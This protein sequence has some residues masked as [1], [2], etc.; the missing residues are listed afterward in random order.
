MRTRCG[1]LVY[2]HH[3]LPDAVVWAL[4]LLLQGPRQAVR[5][6]CACVV[7]RVGGQPVPMSPR[8]HLHPARDLQRVHNDQRG[9]AFALPDDIPFIPRRHPRHWSDAVSAPATAARATGVRRWTCTL[10]RTFAASSSS[11]DVL[12]P[13]HTITA[14]L[15][16]TRKQSMADSSC[17]A[18]SPTS[19]SPSC[20][21]VLDT[22]NRRCGPGKSAGHGTSSPRPTRFASSPTVTAT[23]TRSTM[24]GSTARRLAGAE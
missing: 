17:M 13:P 14:R 6:V 11:T 12:Q 10:A 21:S 24:T 3:D 22:R 4:P 23:S 7:G 9:L 15:C 19:Q 2:W 18:R 8:R 16:P 5:P 20:G 1:A